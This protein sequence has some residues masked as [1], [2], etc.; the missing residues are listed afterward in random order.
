MRLDK[1]LYK[2]ELPQIFY[3]RKLENHA[4]WSE[5]VIECGFHYFLRQVV[6]FIK[7]RMF[8]VFNWRSSCLAPTVYL[9]HKVRLISRPFKCI[10][11]NERW[12]RFP[13]WKISDVE[14]RRSIEDINER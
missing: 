8:F 6:F 14:L 3:W 7:I 4:V 11:S 12:V 5:I 13:N 2:R 10:V 9:F 1:A